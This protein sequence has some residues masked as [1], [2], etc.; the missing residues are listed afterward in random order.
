MGLKYGR[1]LGKNG[2]VGRYGNVSTRQLDDNYFRR[3]D[4][5]N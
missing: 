4:R 3:L 1:L 2:S 5:L